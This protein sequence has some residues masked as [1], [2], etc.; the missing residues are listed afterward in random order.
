LN[1]MTGGEIVA[2]G[3]VAKA[4]GEK[5]FGEDE[6]TK[7]VLLRRA[8]GTA[9]MAAAAR[10][11]A[12]RTAVVERIKLKLLQPFAFLFGVGREYFEDTFPQE[13][14]AKLADVPAEN[15]VT[16]SPT[17]AGPTLLA[18]SYTHSEPSLK[19]MYLNLLATASDN[20]RA[21]QAHPAFAEIIKQLS[22]DEAKV[23]NSI[24]SPG[25]QIPLVRLVDKP[26]DLLGSPANNFHILMP[27]LLNLGR[28]SGEL[29]EEPRIAMWIDNWVRLG[30]VEAIYD[31]HVSGEHQYDW[32]KGRPEYISLEANSEIDHVD[33]V[34]GLLRP[35]SFGRQFFSAVR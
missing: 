13:M 4:V 35:T 18:L 29:A 25:R 24:V 11:M 32:V 21:G 1:L 23:L 14:A 28:P 15:I 10:T 16:P 8:D 3:K 26:V 6:K 12:A 27:H 5:V 30:L 9:E 22:P 2:A 34:K 7:D 17:V 19:D 31:E 33:F 20:R